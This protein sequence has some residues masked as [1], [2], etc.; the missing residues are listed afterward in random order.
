MKKALKGRYKAVA[1]PTFVVQAK[2]GLN[3]FLSCPHNAE[4]LPLPEPLV[5]H[6][7]QIVKINGPT[8]VKVRRT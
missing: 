6:V 4:H 7:G 2:N 1:I 8:I 3:Y 5:D